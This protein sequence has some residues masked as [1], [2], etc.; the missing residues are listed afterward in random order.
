MLITAKKITTLG[1]QKS[2]ARMFPVEGGTYES[3]GNKLSEI[4]S[5]N[6]TVHYS[7]L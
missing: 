5:G 2:S 1:L 6:E 3:N 7:D 4:S